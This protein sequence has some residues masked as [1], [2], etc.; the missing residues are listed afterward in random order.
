MPPLPFNP[1]QL[2]AAPW[3]DQRGYGGGSVLARMRYL[4]GHFHRDGLVGRSIGANCWSPR[5]CFSAARRRFRF[6]DLSGVGNGR[7]IAWTAH[8]DEFRLAIGH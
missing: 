1:G 5:Q 3:F 7:T 8:D 2:A 4:S 6:R